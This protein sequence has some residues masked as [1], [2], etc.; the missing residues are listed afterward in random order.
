MASTSHT[1]ER[2][3]TIDRQL[4]IIQQLFIVNLNP[5]LNHFQLFGRQGSHSLEAHF[6][7][8]QRG[9]KQCVVCLTTCVWF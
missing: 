4:P 3:V 5:R 7:L 1:T 2:L 6:I 8:A 9:A